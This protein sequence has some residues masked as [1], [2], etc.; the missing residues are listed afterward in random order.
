MA[1]PGEISPDVMATSTAPEASAAKCDFMVL[2]RNI[3]PNHAGPFKGYGSIQDVFKKK[4]GRPK[5]HRSATYVEKYP[6]TYAFKESHALETQA[7][8]LSVLLVGN[9]LHEVWAAVR[10]AYFVDKDSNRT[11]GE[12][13][14]EKYVTLAAGMLHGCDPDRVFT[15]VPGYGD[16]GILSLRE[17]V[18]AEVGALVNE[19]FQFAVPASP[20]KRP[21]GTK[22]TDRRYA[23]Y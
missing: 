6:H 7:K 22:I 4:R 2:W 23:P 15:H 18:T 10:R 17:A 12:A 9:Q 8:T 11:I 13:E 16:S 20:S 19:H 21:D 5:P 14:Y 1:S 3:P